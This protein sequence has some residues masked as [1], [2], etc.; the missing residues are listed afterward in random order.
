MRKQTK[1]SPEVR[2]RPLRLV[3]E[4]RTE[5]PSR[6]AGVESIAPMV[7]GYSPRKVSVAGSRIF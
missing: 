6:W 1:F 3:P 4:Q 5:H 2:E 7:G